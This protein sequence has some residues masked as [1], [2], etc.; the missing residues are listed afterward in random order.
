MSNIVANTLTYVGDGIL[1]GIARF[2]ERSAGVLAYFRVISGSISSNGTSKKTS[3]KWKVVLPFPDAEPTSCP[4]DG[5]A[6]FSDTIIN[7]DI[8][9]DSRSD[10]A[11]RTAVYNTVKDLIAS[12][13]YQSSVK[14]LTLVP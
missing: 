14:D 1:N 2:T 6:P 11:Y 3:V 10:L 12:T 13:N 8:R 5:A 4:C 9:V 7:V